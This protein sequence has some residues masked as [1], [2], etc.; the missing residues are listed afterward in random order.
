MI[1][2]GAG[3]FAKELLQV[4]LSEKYDF[5]YK[6]LFFYDDMNN[7]SGKKFFDKFTI[8]TSAGE[9]EEIFKNQ[10]PDFC[11]GV[12]MSKTRYKLCKKFENSGGKV[13]SIISNNSSLGTFDMNIEEGVTIMSEVTISNAVKI[14]KCS[15]INVNVMIGHDSVIG[16]FCDI[17][18]GVIITGHCE[19]GNF[20][21]VSTG[22][23]ILPGVKIGSN[24]IISAGSVISRDIPENSKVVGTIPSRVIE[25]LPPFNE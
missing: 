19:L 1:V 2:I 15:L 9:V 10:S 16:D 25:K 18:P 13:R 6:N 4:L 23:I 7:I 11:V 21:E 17:S 3:G 8:L 14:G 24:S 22:V 12:G 5:N 20:V